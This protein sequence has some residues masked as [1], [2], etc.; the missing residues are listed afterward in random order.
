MDQ[1]QPPSNNPNQQPQQPQYGQQQQQQ[2]PQYGQQPQQYGRP[3]PGQAPQ[4][5]QQQFP[6]Y[7]GGVSAASPVAPVEKPQSLKYAVILMYV[8]A[9]LSLIG[10]IFSLFQIDQVLQLALS[11]A[12]TSELSGSSYEAAKSVA[13]ATAYGTAI[14]GL[15][16]STALWIW[17]ALAN[18]GGKSWARIVATVFAAIGILGGAYSL[19]SGFVTQM[20]FVNNLIFGVLTLIVSIAALVLIWLKPSTEYYKFKS[21][22]VLY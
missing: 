12:G 22:K 16:V 17:M 4:Y 21:Q 8:G 3:Q 11:Q 2:P 14:F 1:F 5:P 6:G 10:G 19:I 9:A 18:D 20:I 7:P 15:V 13:Q